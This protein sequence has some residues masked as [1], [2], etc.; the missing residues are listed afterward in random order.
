MTTMF[1]SRF[2]AVPCVV[3]GICAANWEVNIAAAADGDLADTAVIESEATGDSVAQPEQVAQALEVPRRE[4]EVRRGETV[5]GRNRPELDPLGGRV[6]GFLVLPHITVGEE[7]NDNIFAT[8]G[9][10]ES[11][12]IT[13]I[14][15]GLEVRSL[16]ANH[17]L[18]FDGSGNIGRYASNGDEN[19]EDYSLGASGR[20]DV[21]RSTNLRARVRYQDL[22]EDRGS[23]DNAN[24]SEPT[25]YDVFSAGLTGFHDFGRVNLTLDGAFDRYN[26]ND[27]P[28][29][30]GATIEQ[31]D[32]DRDIA[33]GSVRVGYEIVDRY[34]AFVRGTYNNR[35]Y[36]TVNPGTQLVRDSDGY[37]MVAGLAMDFGGVVFGD[38]FAGYV[39]Q[40]YDDARLSTV[41]GPTVGAEVTWNVTP[42]T[43]VI[44]SVAREIAETTARDGADFASGR[45]LTTG[46][47]SV[48]HEVLRNL[49]VGADAAV[50]QDDFQGID[51]TDML[52]TAGVNA[53]YM[54]NRNFYLSG[55]YTYRQRNGDTATGD[56]TENLFM[57]SVKAQY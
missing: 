21:R 53:V 30:G 7:Y 25:K 8:D 54:M 2:W 6:G 31:D 49:L 46:R 10:A 5:T 42:L 39:S 38:F 22:H 56:Y 11:D 24:G 34:E 18:R 19:F 47:L 40:N 13:R 57:V 33:Q 20:L 28:A 16:W 44:G 29:A 1:A 51:R 17:E 27:V 35:T 15:P 55:G 4:T 32:R 3:L 52:Y 23:P 48:D 41:D 43:T 50:T 45:F 12:F 36:D 14:R 26:F 9:N 37:E